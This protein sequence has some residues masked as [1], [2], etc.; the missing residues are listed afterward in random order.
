MLTLLLTIAGIALLSASIRSYERE[1][2]RRAMVLGAAAAAALGLAAVTIPNMLYLQK[3]L[4]RLAMPT[5]ILWV[6][7]GGL[8]AWRWHVRDRRGFA[9]AAALFV[10]YTASGSPGVGTSLLGVLERE[11]RDIDPFAGPKLDAVFL[12]GGGTSVDGRSRALLGSAGDRVLLAAQLVHRD[13]AARVVTSGATVAGMGA[14]RDLAAE[15]ASILS[16]MGVDADRVVQLDEGKNSSQEIRAYKA[17]ADERGWTRMGLVTSAWHMR[18]AMRLAENAGL[19]VVPLPADFRGS[20]P[21]QGILFFVPDGRGFRD[22]SAAC[23]EFLG[24]AVGR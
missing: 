7:L 12:M 21:V 11:Y 8:A 23:W 20:F 16:D 4:G 3:V 6:V 14:S 18:R 10:F 1:S 13:R 24:A 19:E 9:V 2:K 22:V 15:T 5:G 17:L